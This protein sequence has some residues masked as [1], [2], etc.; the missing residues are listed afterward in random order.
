VAEVYSAIGLQTKTDLLFKENRYTES[1]DYVLKLE[2]RYQMPGRVIVWCQAYKEKT[3]DKRYDPEI[4][5]RLST[6][7][8]RGIEK[9]RLSDFGEPGEAGVMFTAETAAMRAEGIK[10]GDIVVALNGIR[11]FDVPQYDY[12]R[13]LAKDPTLHFILWDG[14]RYVERTASPPNY[15]F[16]VPIQTVKRQTNRNQISP[17]AADETEEPQP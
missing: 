5:K 4:D 1:F 9:A 11:V 14:S 7:F 3:G 16:G 8:P 12:V 2:E 10:K 13:S 15:R 6:L 17:P